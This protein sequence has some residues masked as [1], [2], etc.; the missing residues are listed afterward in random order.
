MRP[1][2][3]TNPTIVLVRRTLLLLDEGV[4]HDPLTQPS[5]SFFVASSLNWCCDA[6]GSLASFKRTEVTREPSFPTLTL[7]SPIGRPLLNTP[8]P[9]PVSVHRSLTLV[10]LVRWGKMD[11]EARLSCA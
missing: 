1:A 7:H 8:L 3:S 10:G 2:C 5:S 4:Y 6:G 11:L 9:R